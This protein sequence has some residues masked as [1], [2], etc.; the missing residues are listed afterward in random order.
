MR[1]FDNSHFH[2][3]IALSIAIFAVDAVTFSGV[4]VWVLYTVPLIVV[5][6]APSAWHLFSV[7]GICSLFISGGLYL[8]QPSF[9]FGQE[10]LGRLLALACVWILAVVLAERHPSQ[11]P[12]RRRTGEETPGSAVIQDSVVY[13]ALFTELPGSLAAKWGGGKLVKQEARL[14]PLFDG[15]DMQV[16]NRD[17]CG[18]SC[19]FATENG[20][21]R[22]IDNLQRALSLLTNRARSEKRKAQR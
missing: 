10:L 15:G 9:L 20:I 21:L 14:C 4:A 7:S 13:P 12:A 17:T 6:R 8:P 11:K 5:S 18:E 22:Q 1:E 3:A 19:I 16:A 2:L